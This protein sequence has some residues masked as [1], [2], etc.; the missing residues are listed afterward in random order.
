MLPGGGV[1]HGETAMQAATREV[2]EETG[3]DVM[4]HPVP[5]YVTRSTAFFV[6]LHATGTLRNGGEGTPVWATWEH[7]FAHPRHGMTTRRVA[8]RLRR[9]G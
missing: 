8:E 2:A 7:L 4:L 6:A 3:L 5:V 1:E 9:D